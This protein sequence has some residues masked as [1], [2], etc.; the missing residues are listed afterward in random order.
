MV[1]LNAEANVYG[2]F[3][4]NDKL[5]VRRKLDRDNEDRFETTHAVLAY[6]LFDF[7]PTMLIEIA[8][9]TLL[10]LLLLLFLLLLLLLLLLFFNYY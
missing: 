7:R 8:V 5:H 1:T 9:Y 6:K 2:P 4:F 10:L 3:S